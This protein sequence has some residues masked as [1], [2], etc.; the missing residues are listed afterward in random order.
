MQQDWYNRCAVIPQQTVKLHKDKATIIDR[1]PHRL[2]NSKNET[3]IHRKA[4]N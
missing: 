1:T 3:G 2:H 4:V